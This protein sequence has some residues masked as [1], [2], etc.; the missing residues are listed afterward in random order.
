MKNYLLNNHSAVMRRWQ[1]TANV[2][3]MKKA[4]G[5]IDI[6]RLEIEDLKKLVSS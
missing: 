4:K 2:H 3:M 1:Y 5:K 6:V